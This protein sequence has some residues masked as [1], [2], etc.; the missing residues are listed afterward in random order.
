MQQNVY[1]IRC[2]RITREERSFFDTRKTLTNIIVLA[3]HRQIVRII[4]NAESTN[5]SFKI[6]Q[7]RSFYRNIVHLQIANATNVQG[8]GHIKSLWHVHVIGV[9]QLTVGQFNANGQPLF[10][11]AQSNESPLAI[12]NVGRQNYFPL[13]TTRHNND[14]YLTVPQHQSYKMFFLRFGSL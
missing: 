1:T 2:V 3:W 12:I 4:V 5:A 11:A 6:F 8:A 10:D 7:H 9:D 14:I 13:F